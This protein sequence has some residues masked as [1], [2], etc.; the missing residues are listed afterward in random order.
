MKKYN[1]ILNTI[2]VNIIYLKNYFLQ[3]IIITKRHSSNINTPFQPNL[4]LF[5]CNQWKYLKN[6]NSILTTV[7]VNIIYLKNYFL[8]IIII[9]KR[10]SS[11]LN[12]PFQPKLWLFKCNQTKYLEIYNLISTTICSMIYLNNYFLLMKIIPQWYS[13]NLNTLFQI[14]FETF[15]V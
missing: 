13:S 7:C 6:Y 8:Q 9:T 12:T 2:C 3:I 11:N 5:E 14:K 10:H 4:W 1:S 15:W